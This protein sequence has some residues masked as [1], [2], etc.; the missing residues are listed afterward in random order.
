MTP[1]RKIIFLH[2]RKTGGTA[3]HN[4][5]IQHFPPEAVCGERFNKPMNWKPE[6]LA[7]YTVFSGHFSYSSLAR[8]PGPKHIFTVLRDPREQLL[9]FFK[10]L[11][12][13]KRNHFEAQGSKLGVVKEAG[14]PNFARTVDQIGEG[15][16]AK[17][18]F[19]LCG[20]RAVGFTENLGG[21]HQLIWNALG[22]PAPSRPLELTNVTAQLQG[23]AFE[24][25]T[26]PDIAVSPREE[27]LLQ[28]FTRRDRLTGS[29]VRAP[30]GRAWCLKKTSNSAMSRSWRR[31][32]P[33][34]PPTSATSPCRRRSS[35]RHYR[36]YIVGMAGI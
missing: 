26:P 6:D 13:H 18:I 35:G 5:L 16:I 10:F 12:H 29:W 27:I 1:G 17:T 3:L 24:D 8:I 25:H 30:N 2:L 23:G 34:P 9:S 11:K 14:A 19:R 15:S 32:I 28:R 22:L 20:F 31:T 36:H 21:A 4:A 7:R 33:M